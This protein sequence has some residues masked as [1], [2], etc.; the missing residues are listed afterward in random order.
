MTKQPESCSRR[1]SAVRSIDVESIVVSSPGTLPP[2]LIIVV[3]RFRSGVGKLKPHQTNGTHLMMRR[4]SP[5]VDARRHAGN[6]RCRP[7]GLL[8]A[9]VVGCSGAPPSAQ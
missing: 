2:A 9:L 8:V 4:H 3:L 6:L 5:V 1:N 7:G